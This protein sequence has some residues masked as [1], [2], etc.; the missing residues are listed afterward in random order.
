M[1]YVRCYEETDYQ[2]LVT[3]HEYDYEDRGMEGSL[4]PSLA[5]VKFGV[6]FDKHWSISSHSHFYPDVDLE[7]RFCC[8]ASLVTVFFGW[9]NLEAF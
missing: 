1:P 3:G 5:H 6:S 4:N 8:E 2:R 7:T 9:H